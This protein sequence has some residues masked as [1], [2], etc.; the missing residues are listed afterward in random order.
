[1]F[2]SAEE[3]RGGAAPAVWQGEVQPLWL[4]YEANPFTGKPFFNEVR[5]PFKAVL[6]SFRCFRVEVIGGVPGT[7]FALTT[8]YPRMFAHLSRNLMKCRQQDQCRWR[9][10]GTLGRIISILMH[11]SIAPWMLTPL[12]ARRAGGALFHA[13]APAGNQRSV[14]ELPWRRARRHQALEV[15]HGPGKSVSAGCPKSNTI[16]SGMGDARGA[17]HALLA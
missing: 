8:L 16:L 3:L 1:M 17:S 14:L 4:S 11:E 2:G 6:D 15:W 9:S 7:V 5:A 10:G 12:E 13:V